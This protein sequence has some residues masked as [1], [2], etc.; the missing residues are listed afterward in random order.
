MSHEGIIL[1]D[2]P[3]GKTSFYLVNVLRRIL[4]VRKIGH[5][6][7][8]DPFATGVMVMLVGRKYTQKADLFLK[9]G[10]SYRAT[11]RLGVETDTYD[12]DGKTVATSE[13][14]PSEEEIRDALTHFQG[15]VSQVPPM[16]SAKKING[17]K[18]YELARKGEVVE[19]KPC[20]VHL[21]TTLQRY[22]YPE[23]EIDVACSKGTYLRSIAH[24]L[25]QILGT[26]AHLTHLI[27]TKS[28]HFKLSDC[29]KLE[30]LNRDNITR[31]L[32]TLHESHHVA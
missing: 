11:I 15:Q 3:S 26:G 6:G 1:I 4:G 10:K 14:I 25:G 7:T 23:V 29:V 12:C 20:T 27:R 13:H 5:A 31:H 21:T 17:K 2:K 9:E 16:F 32:F 8:L 19:R 24:D 30:N 22:E 18:L 28:G